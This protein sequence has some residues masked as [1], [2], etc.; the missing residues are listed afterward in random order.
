MHA[1]DTEEVLGSARPQTVPQP[2]KTFDAGIL[3][4][5]EYGAISGF[6]QNG[7]EDPE[8]G[9]ASAVPLQRRRKVI[10]VGAGINGIQQATLLLKDGYV[11]HQD[12]QIFDALEGYGGVWQKNRYPGCA[13]DVPA[14]IYTTSYHINKKWT[15]FY[16]KR[17]EIEAY[18]T[19][20]AMQYELDRCTQFGSFVKWCTWD[21]DHMIWHVGVSNKRTGETEHWIAD[22]VCQ[23]VGSLDRPKWGNTPGR[24]GF[25]GI[26]WHTAHWRDDY[27]LTGK[28]VAIIGCGPSAAQLIPEIIS[29]PKH[30][31]VYMRTPPV[32]VGRG[33]FAYSSLFRW[34]IRWVPLFA[35]FIRQRMNLR[36]MRLGRAM[37]TDGDP[38][39]DQMTATAVKFMESQ[40][41][42]PEL[43]EKVR[44]YSK[45][46]CKRPLRLDGFYP[47]L[48]RSNCTVLRENLIRYTEKGVLS[49]DRVTGTETER[50]YDV[51][52]FGT[53]FNVAQFLEH[54]KVTGLNGIDLQEK[55]KAHPE[56][57][58]GLATSQ[59]P[60]MFYC[61]GP[62]SAHVWSSQQDN[63]ERQARF[64]AQVVKE[65]VLRARK[66]IKLAI[67]PK[68]D[69]ERQYNDE[70]QR[71]QAG[72]FVWTRP[73]CVTYYKNDDGWNTYTMP[74][75]WWQFRQ[76]LRKIRWDEWEVIEKPMA[77]VEIDLD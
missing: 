41:S 7:Q 6:A 75:T 12:I 17:P 25:T 15:H 73:D 52:I 22:V 23:C 45:Y 70:V 60:N 33:D 46:Y 30:L 54:E 36:M 19:G 71:R 51:I 31:T 67:H 32:C 16:A 2:V 28:N 4:G 64:A 9:P 47:A 65:S 35:W 55:W 37:A 20:F 8:L 14:M 63:W 43:R 18:Y 13:C 10:I 66:G 27:D 3:D 44:P 56:A 5:D 38:L 40:I 53:G 49:S 59:F 76:M 58:Y 26:S 1:N 21:E 34:A 68:R 77:K 39:N 42:D 74:W 11:K 29:K 62:N 72:T 50:Q 57:L 69:V 61:F 48:A 24:E